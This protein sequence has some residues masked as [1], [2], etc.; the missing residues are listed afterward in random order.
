M[1]AK[2]IALLMAS[3][4][5]TLLSSSAFTHEMVL[6]NAVGEK[7]VIQIQEKDHFL[8]LME[9]VGAYLDLQDG[10]ENSELSPSAEKNFN[11]EVCLSQEGVKAKVSKGK[12]MQRN[13]YKGLTQQEREDICYIVKTL[14]AHNVLEIWGHKSA[15]KKAG[16]RIDHV[17][18][19][20]FLECIFS[21]NELKTSAAS[22]KGKTMVW[23]DFLK[24]IKKSLSQEFRN[25]NLS[26]PFIQDFAKQVNVDPNLLI[27]LIQ[28]QEWEKFVNVLIAN[29]PG[30]QGDNRYNM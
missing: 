2:K 26:E 7:T 10:E 15:L 5:T 24:G 23:D 22:L 27:P 4:V 3:T 18:P 11:I 1:K 20:R 12:Q 9:V 30:T 17:H 21:D 13:Y 16:D 19:L 25:K 29:V 8:S 6:D 28:S 14:A